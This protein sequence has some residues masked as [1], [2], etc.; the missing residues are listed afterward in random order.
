[1]KM[2]FQKPRREQ[3]SV[4]IVTLIL[5]TLLLLGLSTYL[6]L[7]VSQKNLG[8]RSQTWNASLALCE[9]GVEE[10]LAQVNSSALNFT[11]TGLAKTDF[12]DNGWGSSGSV[13]GPVARSFP[14]GTY[15]VI[16]PTNGP[17]PTIYATGYATVPI[18]GDQI[19]RVVKV[20]TTRQ[21]LFNVGIGAIGN[22]DFNGNGIITD[23]YNSQL[24]SLS[25][26]AQYDPAKTST[27]GSIASKEGLIDLGNHTI[28]GDEYLGPNAA[29]SNNGT[30]TG[31]T[32]YDYNVQFPD[33][34]LPPGANGWSIAPATSG[35]YVF[36]TSGNYTINEDRPVTVYPGVTVN[37]NVTSSD[38]TATAIK[39]LGGITNAGTARFF[40]NG[41][42][43][44]S[45]AGN[46]AVNP[47]RPINLVFYG[48][49][50]LTSITFSGTT[51]FQG[52]IYAPE[53]NIA[54]NGGG[55]AINL[56]GSVIV[57]NITDNGHYLIH[58]DESLADYGPSRGYVANSW[59]ELF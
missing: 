29:N 14:G 33:V 35:T 25:T 18:V 59:L 8:T 11:N 6:M 37:L 44:V 2:R 27:N 52:V 41:P 47:T 54:L 42:S 10:A 48:L 55:N 39:I 36:T 20:T 56:S 46:T 24:A 5:G 45:I 1:M 26:A 16:V 31:T 19:S 17:T 22:I 15:A 9:A 43:S 50:S 34:I 53:A 38:F 58:Y 51:D 21:G 23:S 28:K 4:L 7:L 30:V 49:P 32:Y 3:G 13:Y 40:L 12:S 57:K